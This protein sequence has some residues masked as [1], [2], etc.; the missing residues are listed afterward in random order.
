MLKSFDPDM[1]NHMN[2]ENDKWLEDQ[3]KK[4]PDISDD[5]FSNLIVEK[6]ELE[7]I[8][9][10]HSRRIILNISY[11]LSFALLL[12]LA[13]WALIAENINI[14]QN[15]ILNANGDLTAL[16]MTGISILFITAL[17]AF[18]LIQESDG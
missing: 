16:P 18:I 2:N 17:M 4:S 8:I 12:I 15:N 11:I 13:P 14:W 9:K 6:I 10:S 7:Q 5:G 3:L 1:E